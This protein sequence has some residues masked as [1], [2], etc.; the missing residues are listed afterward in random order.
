MGICGAS[1]IE[2]PDAP[3]PAPPRTR[4]NLSPER[5]RTVPRL[6]LHSNP[7]SVLETEGSARSEA[8]RSGDNHSAQNGRKKKRFSFWQNIRFQDSQIYENFTRVTKAQ[9]PESMAFIL[10]ALKNTFVFKD[11]TD[12]DFEG[13]IT[14]MFYCE[15]KKNDYVFRQ[16]DPASC[17]FIVHKGEC[18]V[19][20]DGVIKKRLT[21]GSTFGELALLYNAPRS[22]SIRAASGVGLWAIDKRSFRLIIE[23]IAEKHF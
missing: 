20:I 7:A 22:A 15:A 9:T 6:D 3:V 2:Q 1:K 4:S 11:L 8:E 18:E 14:N 5:G 23:G 17:Y 21:R 19:E 13:I 12:E 10:E 16:N